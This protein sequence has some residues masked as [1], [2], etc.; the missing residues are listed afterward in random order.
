MHKGV[1]KRLF[2]LL[3]ATVLAAALLPADL[4]V[5]AAAIDTAINAAGDSNT[6]EE[7]DHVHDEITFTAWSDPTSLPTEAGHYYLTV[8][9]MLSS[10]WYA[11]PGVT[12]IC[13]N[14]H[15]ITGQT[16]LAG[17]E[18]GQ[19]VLDLYD[20]KEAGALTVSGGTLLNISSN[21]VFNMYGGSISGC[22]H[23]GECIRVMSDTS[24]FNMY[25]GTVTDNSGSYIVNGAGHFNMYGG[26]VS[27]NSGIGVNTANFSISGSPV[28]R[29]NKV[30]SDGTET[31]KN[32]WFMALSR[33]AIAGE[34]TEGADIG[35][36]LNKSLSCA[37]PF[38]LTSGLSGK[39][40]ASAFSADE[41][42][43]VRVNGDGEAELYVGHSW[44]EPNW[45]WADDHSSAAATFTCTVCGDEQEVTDSAPVETQVSAADCENDKVVKYTA[46]VTFEGEEYSDTTEEVVLS[47][48]ATGHSYGAPEW[49]WAA[50][51]SNAA[52]TFR[53]AG[54][55]DEQTVTDNS[56]EM[57]VVSEETCTADK[58]VKYEA[59]VT[60]EGETFTD[61]TDDV[62]IAD[63]AL[64][65]EW[66][67]WT[68]TAAP[69]CTEAGE[70]TRTCSRCGETETRPVAALG[71]SWKAPEWN[72]EG[73]A[74]AT[75]TFVCERDADGS[76]TEILNAEI[77]SEQGTGE[78]LGKTVYTATVVGP[79]EKTYTDVLKENDTYTVTWKN[80]DGEML[81]TDENVPYGTTPTYDGEEPARDPD[82]EGHYSFTGW[83]P[84]AAAVG[85]DAV[86]TAVF[87]SETHTYGEPEWS[88]TETDDGWT[89]SAAFTCS[90]C[91]FELTVPAAKPSYEVTVEPTVDAEGEGVYTAA[92]TGPDGENYTDT[93]AV[94]I[95][96]LVASHIIVTDK[97][98]G[99]AATT[100]DAN[101]LYVGENTFTVTC[102]YRNNGK[103]I[104]TGCV[105]AVD[106]GDGTYTKLAV[107]TIN[108]VHSFTVNVTNADVR[109]VIVLK[110]DVCMDGEIDVGDLSFIKQYMT[111][112]RTLSA[113][114]LLAA[115]ACTDDD[116]DVAD[117]SFIKQLMTYNGVLRIAHAS[118]SETFGKYGEAPNQRRTGVTEDNP[119]G[120]MDGELNVT[121]N[122]FNWSVIYRPVNKNRAEFIASFVIAAV[123]NGSHIGYSQNGRTGVF[124]S[125]QAMNST[126]P[127]EI[128][129][130]VNCDCATLVGA[131]V[132][133]SGLHWSTLRKLCTWEMV[134]VLGGSDEFIV[135]T[136]D[137]M[138]H[139][140]AGIKRGDILFRSGHTAVSIDKDKSIPW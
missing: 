48:T 18:S 17:D 74:S 110:G 95:A 78:D 122:P 118:S 12:D 90:D 2:S 81:E 140:G 33:I 136:D 130:L 80:W 84:E 28:I 37:E 54:E 111:R 51:Y 71:H 41:G 44:G 9:V 53:C 63:T 88:W 120:N 65:H 73:H 119:G 97:T 69:G 114:Q 98:G 40:D 75:A 139:S 116:I 19:V 132:Y 11:A 45:V 104:D 92:V 117:L 42:Y 68:Q 67:E 85:G 16:E 29:N 62:V 123:A 134:D 77:K 102:A 27:N 31:E 121:E 128:T 15:S 49:E 89:A 138:L 59:S 100:V 35:V 7:A 10:K 4:R 43:S 26:S 105:I 135:L 93:K 86:Y 82:Q 1:M 24:V 47:G 99:A 38:V 79:D 20:C 115:D 96:K 32:V 14:G 129:D 83:S 76:H 23:S 13:L 107:T 94:T 57:I 91:G 137:A 39:G 72:W 106:N 101:A 103:N 36:T 64:G 127:A 34:L 22:D 109:L 50:D 108:G 131:A 66:G 52:A 6:V 56:P 5:K 46:K 126:D 70:E 8:N 133:Y 113:L 124:D 87:A 112:K 25:A 30:T 58:V 125:L 3:M 55:D 21:A 61:T 60:F